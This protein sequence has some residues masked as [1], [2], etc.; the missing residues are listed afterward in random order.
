MP[1]C[2]RCGTRTG[3]S[4]DCESCGLDMGGDLVTDGGQGPNDR[5]GNQP[6]QPPGNNQP[7]GGGQGQPPQ[8]GGQGRQPQGGG[9]GQQPRG[10]QPPGQ[11]QSRGNQ[12]RAPPQ[13]GNDGFSRRQLLIGGGGGV[14]ALGGIWFFFLRGGSS[15]GPEGTVEAYFSALDEGDF[16]RA[17]ELIHP[18]SPI[19]GTFGNTDVASALEQFYGGSIS[20]SVESTEVVDQN[21]PFDASNQPNVQQFETVETTISGSVLGQESSSSTGIVIVAQDSNGEWKIWQS[22]L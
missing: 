11:Q 6:N 16:E 10:Q 12:R 22:Q 7:Q 17:S 15:G 2:P 19:S 20:I 18:D 5:Q 8:G 9:Q 21:V 14:A 4:T 1:S 13:Q 3:G